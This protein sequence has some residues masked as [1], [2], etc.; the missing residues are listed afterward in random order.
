[1]K[2]LAI[3]IFAIAT[4]NAF[5]AELD[6]QKSNS[7]ITLDKK[8]VTIEAD[9]VMTDDLFAMVQRT[10]GSTDGNSKVSV[11]ISFSQKD[12]K[13]SDGLAKVFNCSGMTKKASVEL[14]ISSRS[15]FGNSSMQLMRRPVRIENID[16]SSSIGSNG[17]IVLGGESTTV[18]LDQVNVTSSMFVK[19]N[20]DFKLDLS[21]SFNSAAE[22]K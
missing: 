5:S 15:Q 10:T 11:K 4:L 12:L 22:C 18:T 3:F 9:A 20:G 14:N 8:N 21:Q 16:I 17:G 19:M 13:C 2:S 6:C 7:K 1:M